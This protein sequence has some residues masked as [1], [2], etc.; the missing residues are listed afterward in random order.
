MRSLPRAVAPVVL[1]AALCAVGGAALA[2]PST[3]GTVVGNAVLCLDEV[4]NK[5]FYS[6]MLTLFGPAYKHEGG[7][8]WFKAQAT[9][10]GTPVID[11]IISDDTSELVFVGAVIDATPPKVEEAVLAAAG[12]HFKKRD[13]S[14]YPVRESSPGSRIVYFDKKAKIYCAKYKHLPPQ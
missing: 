13:A 9:L 10:W 2:V 11:V 14:A 6:Y 5:S 8:Y 4:D 3:F 7:A 1:A 12:M